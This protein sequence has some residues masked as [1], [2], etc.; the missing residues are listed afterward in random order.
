M[1][2]QT[3]KTRSEIKAFFVPNAIPAADDFAAF[4]DSVVNQT[5]DGVRIDAGKLSVAVAVEANAGLQVTGAPVSVGTPESKQSLR[6]HGTA[7]VS[8]VLTAENGFTVSSGTVFLD[9]SATIAGHLA[10]AGQ[11]IAHTSLT[12]TGPIAA[13]GGPVTIGTAET[14]LP[15]TVHHSLTVNRET[16]LNKGLAVTGGGVSIG[17]STTPQALTVSGA[18]NLQGG[19]TILGGLSVPSGAVTFGGAIDANGGLSVRGGGLTVGESTAKQ[20]L[21]VNGS[22]TATEVVNANNGLTVNAAVLNANAG[23]NVVG[24]ALTVGASP[25]AQNQNLLVNGTA[26]A[27]MFM[28][29]APAGDTSP[30]ITSRVIP[31]GQG[32]SN[33]S[34]ELILYHGDNA[35]GSGYGP[36]YITLRAPAIRLQTY[37][38]VASPSIDNNATSNTRIDIDSFGA[39][40]ATGA[41]TFTSTL[42]TTGLLSA[43]AGLTVAGTA[44]VNGVANIAQVPRS[45]SHLASPLGAYITGEFTDSAGVEFRHSNGSQGIGFGYNTIYATG[46]NPEQVLRLKARGTSPVEVAGNLSVTG[47]ISGPSNDYMKAQFTMNGG[48][49]VTWSGGRLR[50]S[51]RFIAISGGNSPLS[52]LSG[53]VNVVM[54]ATDL[55]AAY[56]WDN[57]PR[58]VN[59]SGIL[60]KGWEALYAV[61]GIGQ[62]PDAVTLR[63]VSY[64]YPLNVPSNWILVAV[65]NGDDNSIRLATGRTIYDGNQRNYNG[66]LTV[67]AMVT[68]NAGLT[69]TGWAAVNNGG[70]SISQSN[71]TG[72]HPPILAGLY[73]TAN[74]DEASGVEFRHTNGTQGIGFGYNTIYAAGS[75]PDQP[76]RLKGRGANSVEILGDLN[77]AGSLTGPTNDYMR[78]QFTLSGGGTV[79]WAGARLRW[80]TRFLAISAGLSAQAMLNAHITINMPT[81]DL[82]GAWV[83]DGVPR[84]VNASGIVLTGYEALYAVHL[85][86]QGPAAVQ[87]RIVHYTIAHTVPANWVLIAVVNGDDGSLKLGTGKTIYAGNNDQVLGALTVNGPLVANTGLSVMGSAA[88]IGTQAANQNLVVNGTALANAFTFPAPYGDYQ[89]T[90]SARTI[91]PNQGGSNEATELILFHSNDP[92]GSG[93]GADCITLRAPELRFQTFADT[94]V[95]DIGNYL[96]ANTRFSINSYGAIT[97]FGPF[98]ANGTL[99][100]GQLL[101]AQNGLT[102]ANGTLTVNG[103]ANLNAGATVTG[104]LTANGTLYANA[105]LVANNGNVIVNGNPNATLL[106]V[107]GTAMVTQLNFTAPPGDPSPYITARTIPNNQG[108]SNEAT[109]LILYHGN[110]NGTNGSGPDL[111]TLRAPG[112]RLQTYNDPGVYDIGNL[113]GS[114]NRVY[115]EPTGPVNMY[116]GIL[117]LGTNGTNGQLSSIIGF[118]GYGAAHG[119]L[120]FRPGAGFELID[121]SSVIPNLTILRDQYPYHDLRV[122]LIICQ[123]VAQP[124]SRE[125][126]EDI[127]DLSAEEALD[128]FQ[129]LQPVKYR[130]KDDAAG[131]TH[132]GFIAEDVPDLV[133][134]NGRTAIAPV[135]ILAVLT[136][137]VHVQ[138]EAIQRL[139]AQI[140]A[141]TPA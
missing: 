84:S 77:I 9:T 34:T 23:L 30:V 128:A 93:S 37:A 65:M 38:S 42:T 126:K 16:A 111:I 102:M 140:A 60:L 21:M 101:T 95:A 115:I 124:S 114:V 141:L 99:N 3:K 71:R 62:N 64:T 22:V 121:A 28:L 133:S 52:M 48:G 113:N 66:P 78:A 139:E 10:I 79:T 96:G 74:F 118:M 100:T 31:S 32:A 29:A 117:R 136:R 36:D 73:V 15:M 129:K 44:T 55:P 25:L 19:A 130:M 8:D 1:S 88:T 69:V 41:T 13:A 12:L 7:A 6:V 98:F 87:F 46:S 26:Q 120:A 72:F 58:S 33:E 2:D 11:L 68:A 112:I 103:A 116:Q 123:G 5:D 81:A 109:E 135:D 39:I 134:I 107:N 91:P 18:S 67:S 4:I 97:A 76:L 50:W 47:L 82:P 14:N 80:T 49:V 127:H 51:N 119:A 63:I 43:N 125:I 108:G 70:V 35:S 106:A 131:R 17:D 110:D 40:T 105:A 45:G 86:G 89:P 137:I 54:P 27:K 53:Y 20:N 94:N 90:I 92:S 61:H 59:A 57:Q 85:M 83:Y 56:V 24:G 75:L 138:Q 122:K 132:A 104:T